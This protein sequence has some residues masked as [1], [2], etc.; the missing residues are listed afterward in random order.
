MATLGIIHGS[1]QNQPR[2]KTFNLSQ[3]DYYSTADMGEFNEYRYVNSTNIIEAGRKL[4]YLGGKPN[5]EIL[6]PGYSVHGHINFGTIYK[7]IAYFVTDHADTLQDY[8]S[9]IP[10]QVALQLYSNPNWNP[11]SYS[12]TGV[13][14][15]HP[16][17]ET[18]NVPVEMSGVNPEWQIAQ[19]RIWIK[20]QTDSFSGKMD[21]F[22]NYGD[23][24][25]VWNCNTKYSV[26]V[27]CFGFYGLKAPFPTL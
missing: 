14:V 5:G 13:G 22:C 26:T 21:N 16:I 19:P 1:G 9:Q 4:V 25:L 2:T 24:Y 6:Q 10:K 12:E 11:N 17:Y 3:S 15:P 18:H 23:N 20:V 7:S 27:R 8:F